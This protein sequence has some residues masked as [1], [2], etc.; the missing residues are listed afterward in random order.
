MTGGGWGLRGDGWSSGTEVCAEQ[1]RGGGDGD[2]GEEDE[3]GARGK[4]RGGGGGKGFDGLRGAGG[5]GEA[6][7]ALG[8]EQCD[9]FGGAIA[10]I[11]LGKAGPELADGGAD[12]TVGGRVEVP[13]AAEK[14]LADLGLVDRFAGAREVTFAEV[15][16]EFAGTG[17]PVK[18]GAGEDAGQQFLLG[19]AN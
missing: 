6:V 17:R 16:E 5:E 3:E 13:A 2:K 7:L 15:P 4:S 11:E 12:N 19:W 14:F 10:V 8:D 9:F 1:E 18:W